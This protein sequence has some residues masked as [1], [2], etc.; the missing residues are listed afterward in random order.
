MSI[1][2]NLEQ[3][4]EYVKVNATLDF[5]KAVKPFI[6]DAVEHYI[7]PHLGEELYNLLK[8]Y[9]QT[10]P[11]AANEKYDALLP[12]VRRALARF[13]LFKASPHLDINVGTT[14]YTTAAPATGG[15]APASAARVEK[16]DKGLEVLGWDAIETMLRFLEKNKADYPTWIDSEAYTMNIT[17]LVNNAEE[18][19]KEYKIN[20]SRLQFITYRPKINRVETL[21]IKPVISTALFDEIVA[22]IKAD[23][24]TDLNTTLLQPLR[25]SIIMFTVSEKEN[26][27][28][29]QDAVSYLSEARKILDKNAASYP[30]YLNSEEYRGGDD[31]DYTQFE[32][33][34]D[35]KIFVA[36]AP[37]I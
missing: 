23:E 36:G 20:K 25:I 10:P 19:D 37:F 2:S 22:Q 6:P 8:N 11:E 28:Y 33:T 30:L 21:Q 15:L 12:Y 9:V 1:F 18:F 29:H 5:Q 3:F 32:N 26:D 31:A 4:Q 34:E 27:R 13:T 14:G 7:Y 16:F 24:L 17:G 35:N